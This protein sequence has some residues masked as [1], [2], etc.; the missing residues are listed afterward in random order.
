MS[1]RRADPVRSGKIRGMTVERLESIESTRS[2][3]RTF[4]SASPAPPNEVL[5][6]LDVALQ[7]ARLRRPV[8]GA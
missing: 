2:T 4:S 5:Q 3:S 7:A 8:P 6:I 1:G